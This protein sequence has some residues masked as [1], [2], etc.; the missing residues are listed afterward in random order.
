MGLADLELLRARAPLDAEVRQGFQEGVGPEVVAYEGVLKCVITREPQ[1]HININ[2]FFGFSSFQNFDLFVLVFLF[3][4][5]T[6]P[7]KYLCVKSLIGCVFLSR[8]IPQ[9]WP[10]HGAAA[11]S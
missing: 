9:G 6:C 2:M 5:R 1:K 3:D 10:T 4:F 7:K 11:N 8:I